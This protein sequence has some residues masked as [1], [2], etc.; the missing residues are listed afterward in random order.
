M[1]QVDAAIVRILKA[2]KQANHPTLMS[3]LPGQ[4]KFDSTA[5][6]VK[7]HIETLI[8]RGYLKRDDTDPSVYH[9]LA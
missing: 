9:Y 8:E 4:L 2:H 5:T 6:E 3:E 1:Y 7:E